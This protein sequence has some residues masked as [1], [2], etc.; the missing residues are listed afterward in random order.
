MKRLLSL[1]ALVALSFSAVAQSGAKAGIYDLKGNAVLLDREPCIVSVEVRYVVEQFIPGEYARFA[2][3]LFGERAPLA[4]RVNAKLLSATLSLGRQESPR[5]VVEED[6][7]LAIPSNRLSLEGQTDEER[8]KATAEMIFSLRRDRID[9]ITGEAGEHVFG[10]GLSSALEEIS[11]L[12]REYLAMFFGRTLRKE[13]VQV[14]NIAIDNQRTDYTVCRFSGESGVAAYDDLSAPQVV[15][16]LDVPQ[17][18]T[19]EAIRAVALKS[20]E[21]EVDYL[22]VPSVKC[23]LIFESAALDEKAFAL[24]PFA[25]RLKGAPIK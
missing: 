8:V 24:H 22:V 2:Q 5:V 23:S 6:E 11:R 25:K 7:P 12:E 21:V 4:E 17:N 18:I 3:S 19:H 13:Y 14:F 9:L 16:K 15:L 20:K 1:V 10:A